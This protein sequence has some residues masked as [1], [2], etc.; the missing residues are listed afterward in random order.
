MI[1]VRY[2]SHR[3]IAEVRLARQVL[4]GVQS[5]VKGRLMSWSVIMRGHRFQ[6]VISRQWLERRSSTWW[7]AC[8]R[9]RR[10]SSSWWRARET[11][12]AAKNRAA[13]TAGHCGACGLKEL[14]AHRPRPTAQGNCRFESNPRYVDDERGEQLSA[15]IYISVQS[16]YSDH[17]ADHNS[18]RGSARI[19]R[20]VIARTKAPDTADADHNGCTAYTQVERKR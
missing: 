12:F 17:R 15:R 9:A 4:P 7:R 5:E 13:H 20:P 6:R 8:L 18:S 1:R 10:R 14:T 2:V 16:S 11:V 19:C 3:E